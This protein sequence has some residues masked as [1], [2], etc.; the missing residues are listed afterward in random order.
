VVSTICNICIELREV[1]NNETYLEVI[2]D[3]N[4]GIDN[5]WEI[6]RADADV[7]AS[8][9]VLKNCLLDFRFNAIV[10]TIDFFIVLY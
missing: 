6:L 9:I 1:A 10:S 3:K 7:E 4:K 8:V 5:L 2:Y